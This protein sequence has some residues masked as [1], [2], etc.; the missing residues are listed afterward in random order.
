MASRLPYRATGRLTPTMEA[1][2]VQYV[3]SYDGYRL[4][5]TES[6]DGFP[7]VLLPS[8]INHVQDVWCEGFSVG[9]L[10]RDLS[11]R[12]RVIHYDSRGM[13]LSTRGLP[14]DLTLDAFVTDLEAVTES[15]STGR[16]VLIGFATP[17]FLAVRYALRN[18]ERVAALVLIGPPLRA[19]RAVWDDLARQDWDAF[20]ADHVSRAYTPDMAR[21]VFEMF[22]G[23]STQ[24]D[25]LVS[26]PVWNDARIEERLPELRTPALVLSARGFRPDE[27]RPVEFTGFLPNA[28]LSYLETGLPYGAP[29]EAIACIEPFLTENGIPSIT[30]PAARNGHNGI[31]PH[32]LS[33]REI[34]VLRL[35]AQGRS[36]ARIAE[37]LVISHNT[38]IRHV[39][40]IFA[41]TGSSN[42]TEAASYAHRN[43]LA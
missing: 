33:E 29:G 41:K 5:Y 28:R 24:A 30:P 15:T 9:N 35:I 22:Q 31:G 17:S 40:N 21:R 1:P 8:W 11:G 18:P 39:S 13:G 42:R 7:V 16:F 19:P 10:L 34:E 37:A 43:G 12:Y 32:V 6:G 14:D 38:V 2:P 4:A 3:T 23:W 27:Q 36:N 26:T 20:L 25:Y